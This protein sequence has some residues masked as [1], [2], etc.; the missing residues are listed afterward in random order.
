MEKKRI[1]TALLFAFLSV[2][3]THEKDDIIRVP[4]NPGEEDRREEYEVRLSVEGDFLSPSRGMEGTRSY[5]F[6]RGESDVTDFN[7]FAYS[8]DGTLYSS[9]Y[10]SSTEPSCKIKLDQNRTYRFY[11]LANLGKVEAPFREADLK[12]LS[13]KLPGGEALTDGLPMSC[14]ESLTQMPS[15]DSPIRLKMRRL[16]SKVSFSLDVSALE[17]GALELSSVRVLGAN[18]RLSPFGES[19]AG[20][21]SDIIAGDEASP[22]DLSALREGGEMTFYVP[23]NLQGKLLQGNTD[24]W[25]KVPEQIGDKA[26]KCTYLEVKGKYFSDGSLLGDITYRFYIGADECS[27]FNV[28]GNNSYVI[29]LKLTPSGTWMEGSWKVSRG[30]WNDSRSISISPALLLLD[31]RS[32]GS[33]GSFTISVP[34]GCHFK[35][36]AD[37]DKMSRMRLSYSLSGKKLTVKAE[38]DA[39]TG[40]D[41]PIIVETWDGRWADTAMVRVKDAANVLDVQWGGKGCPTYIADKGLLLVGN[42]DEGAGAGCSFDAEAEVTES[43]GFSIEPAGDQSG[44]KAFTLTLRKPGLKTIYISTSSGQRASIKL[45]AKA[46]KLV[47]NISSSGLSADGSRLSFNT[48]YFSENDSRLSPGTDFDQAL[49]DELLAPSVSFR[50]SSDASM[51]ITATASGAEVSRFKSGDRSIEDFYGESHAGTLLISPADASLSSF[52]G[53]SE[54]RLWIK[55]PFQAFS[56]AK[57]LARIDNLLAFGEEASKVSL[58]TNHGQVLRPGGSLTISIGT[59]SFDVDPSSVIVSGQASDLEITGSSA[60]SFTIQASGVRE[61]LTAG[62]VTLKACVK[63]KISGE[64]T[65]PV[66]IGVLEAYV[67]SD[68][69]CTII[70]VE[71]NPSRTKDKS[72]MVAVDFGHGKTDAGL[73]DVA[74]RLYF[75]EGFSSSKLYVKNEV[76]TMRQYYVDMANNMSLYNLG[77]RTFSKLDENEIKQKFNYLYYEV[78]SGLSAAGGLLYKACN[79]DMMGEKNMTGS[80]YKELKPGV[81]EFY[82]GSSDCKSETAEGRTVIYVSLEGAADSSGKGY[83]VIHRTEDLFGGKGWLK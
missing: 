9:L 64:S 4:R 82:C 53:T 17:Y 31:K 67:H 80:K 61:R 48:A 60:R 8:S 44:K 39:V 6:A 33:S 58:D 46:P 20:G 57:T 35:V 41:F 29:T 40:I 43:E 72:Y 28:E 37:L 54:L 71:K 16:V 10:C 27:D 22:S 36:K 7:I 32:D 51:F 26:G 78:P 14:S 63:N 83:Y 77:N 74:S 65:E 55:N 81:Y 76:S 38:G 13:V 68:V 69:G 1:L 18:G 73:K 5:A 50:N 21:N 23:E 45:E 42:V 24:P 70:G 2:S 34:D 19:R 30:E 15:H 12:A 47:T 3:C 59:A 49:Y 79:V 75:H 11:A 52:T 56:A 62:K 66:P 25:K